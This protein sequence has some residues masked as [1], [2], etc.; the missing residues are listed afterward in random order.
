MEKE[1]SM[2][3]SG[4]MLQWKYVAEKPP[5]DALSTGDVVLGPP[6]YIRI[7]QSPLS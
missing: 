4:R 6:V 3:N 2:S 5:G 7:E 1:G